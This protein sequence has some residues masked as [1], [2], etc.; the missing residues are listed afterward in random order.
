SVDAR[1]DLRSRLARGQAFA[2]MRAPPPFSCFPS[3]SANGVVPTAACRAIARRG[4]GSAVRRLSTLSYL[5]AVPSSAVA[6][7]RR[8]EAL[9]KVDHGSLISVHSHNVSVP[10]LPVPP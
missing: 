9:A 10:A 3:M 6:L 7:L 5:S 2:I 4:R 8:V 1:E